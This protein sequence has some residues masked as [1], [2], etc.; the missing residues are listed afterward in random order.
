MHGYETADVEITFCGTVET[1]EGVEL[2]HPLSAYDAA[3]KAIIEEELHGECEEDFSA[4]GSATEYFMSSELP[5]YYRGELGDAFRSIRIVPPDLD[6]ALAR[7]RQ[8]RS[9]SAENASRK[10]QVS[11]PHAPRRDAEFGSAL[12]RVRE[13]REEREGRLDEP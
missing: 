11:V 1:V 6:E 2:V 4:P 5:D 3:A 13:E 10:R 9:G 12:K 7:F 8:E